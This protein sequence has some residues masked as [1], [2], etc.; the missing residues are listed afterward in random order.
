MFRYLSVLQRKRRF[1][2]DEQQTL[3]SFRYHAEWIE[4]LPSYQPK[5]QK[6]LLIRLDD[7]GDY[8]LFRN[9]LP[10]YKQSSRW[11]GYHITL[12][13][14]EA[15]KELFELLDKPTTDEAIWVNKKEYLQ[16]D[17]YKQQLWLQLRKEGYTAVVCP[18]FT[19]PLLL[20][21]LCRLSTG[22][23]MAIAFDNFTPHKPW[24]EASDELYSELFQPET[25]THEFFINQ[26][27]AEW[28]CN[29]PLPMQRPFMPTQ[30]ET[31]EK[32]IACFIGASTKSR[33]WTEK[34][35]TQ[36][37]HLLN[38]NYQ[39]PVKI[40][41]IAQHKKEAIRIAAKTNAESITNTSLTD[42]ID[43]IKNAA[44]VIAN[45]TMMAHL[46]VSCNV[47]VVIISSGNNFTRF[48]VYEEAGIAGARTVYPPLM[49]KK[50]KQ[51][52]D[53]ALH[54]HIVV[55]SDIASIKANTV[56]TTAKQL[57]PAQNISLQ[58]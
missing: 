1:K 29:V 52:G 30:K 20:D 36:L 7:I 39:L 5:N 22:C 27:F 48:T 33:R 42:V 16:N 44:L 3:L 2:K 53:A 14:N 23:A 54:N 46:A 21:D 15:W 49:N 12:L 58:T 24:K 50:R 31:S 55:T 18:S 25:I 6:L 56:L 19:R 57:L 4:T 51:L 26:Q 40:I 13:G 11:K 35:W 47:P 38:Q 8:L 34:R 17:K 43:V 10:A 37:V 32:Y 45:D 41:G 28:C 9:T